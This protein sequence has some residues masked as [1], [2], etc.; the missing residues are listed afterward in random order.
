M[1]F[2]CG[3]F[4]IKHGS[5]HMYPITITT[6]E[7]CETIKS[8]A[9]MKNPAMFA[10]IHDIDLI[11]KEF[12][13]HRVYYRKH[14]YGFSSSCRESISPSCSVSASTPNSD[15][16]D[17]EVTHHKITAML[18]LSTLMSRQAVSI[19]VLHGIYGGDVNDSRYR[20]KLK[21]LILAKFPKN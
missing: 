9:Q 19:K 14:T 8:Y 15:L 11:A 18:Q 20:A 7:A 4:R 6:I 2:L 10:E 13:L 17:R 16:P 12:K 5:R 1:Q 3:K 21:K